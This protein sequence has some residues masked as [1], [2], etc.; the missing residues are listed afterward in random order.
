[1]QLWFDADMLGSGALEVGISLAITYF[2]LAIITSHV[3]E[4]IAGRSQRRADLLKKGLVKLLSQPLAAR[5]LE[6]PLIGNASPPSGTPP[7]YIPPELFATTLLA[8]LRTVKDDP[9]PPA[10]AAL[11]ETFGAS[12][13]GVRKGIEGWYQQAMDRLT[14]DYKRHTQLW[15]L[16]IAI[17]VTA[18]IGADSVAIATS[19]WHTQDA[20]A[21]VAAAQNVSN[22]PSIQPAYDTLTS[23]SFPM[24]WASLPKDVWGWA[25]KVVGLALTA[26]AVSLGAPFWFDLLQSLVNTRATGPKPDPPAP[27]T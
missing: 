10:I 19:V 17:V 22:N 7:S 13:E 15:L 21:A 23:L 6:H 12:P 16:G 11:L 27:M 3:N 5:V 24:G 4:F 1:M 26:L 2:L 20:R 18:V 25:L 8:V 14:G 9:P